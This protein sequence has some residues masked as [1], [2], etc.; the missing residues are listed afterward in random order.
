MRVLV[1]G[2]SGFIGTALC[3]ALLKRSD[4]VVAWVHSSE[5]RVPGIERV[6]LLEQIEGPI[7]AVVNLAG[8]PIADARWSESRK[9]LL[10]SSRLETTA[11]LVSWM[12]QQAENPSTLISGSAI[13]FY[14]YQHILN[15][16]LI[17]NL[18]HVRKLPNYILWIYT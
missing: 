17:D 10:L 7:D 12:A 1:T 6:D 4:Q 16:V 5:P 8:T 3:K 2:A 13:G 18:I 9:Q 14:G 11:A 15:F